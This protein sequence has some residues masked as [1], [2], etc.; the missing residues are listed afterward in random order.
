MFACFLQW[1]PFAPV[2]GSKALLDRLPE[3]KLINRINQS[4]VRWKLFRDFQQD[5]FCAHDLSS[6]R[7]GNQM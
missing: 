5:L 7:L 1:D 6:Y 4:R 2:Q 3:L